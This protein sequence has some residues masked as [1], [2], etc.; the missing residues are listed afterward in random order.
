MSEF[1][2]AS[3]VTAGLLSERRSRV[4]AIR[5]HAQALFEGGATG[6]QVA[7]AISEATET[8]IRDVFQQVVDQLS[9]DRQGVVAK[10]VAVIAIGGTGRGELCPYSDIDLLFLVDRTARSLVGEVVS[11]AVRNYW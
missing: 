2:P 11:Q 1:I 8:F 9:A 6:I 4:Q 5:S 7:A 3:V 10:N